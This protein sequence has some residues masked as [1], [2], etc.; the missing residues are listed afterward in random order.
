M[1]ESLFGLPV[2]PLLAHAAVVLVPLAAVMTILVAVDPQR[3]SRFGILTWL[4]AALAAVAAFASRASGPGLGDALY[5]TAVPDKVIQHE[6]VGQTA[7]WFA[8]A[9]F[10]GITAL[11]LL[12][13]DA[14]RRRGSGSA[15]LPSIL[16]VVVVLVAMVAAMQMLWA[17]WT[18]TAAHWGGVH[19]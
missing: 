9:L 8:L 17:G 13:S 3:R 2:H 10:G 1:P 4:L 12:D 5:P 14:K 11:L 19:A 16:V 15:L 18:G 6:S 7:P